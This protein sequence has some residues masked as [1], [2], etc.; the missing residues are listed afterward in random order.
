MTAQEI[1]DVIKVQY[2]EAVLEAKLEN[3][4]DPSIKIQPERIHDVAAFLMND[5]RF[6]FD[7]LSCL[8]GVD[9]KGKL[10]VVYH[11]YS[12]T[13]KHK[14]VLKVE[15]PTETPNV[16]SVESIWKTANW[17]EREAFD[18]Y[19]INFVNHP[20][21]RRILLPDDWVGHP[22][23]KDYQTPEFYNGMKVPY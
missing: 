9:Y 22:L 7:Y 12:M 19:G 6:Q 11:L 2:G 13:F 15:V 23:R 17:H 10:G 18:M 14:I 8:S 20:D 16:Q 21:Q 4:I 1:Y 3:V 5:E